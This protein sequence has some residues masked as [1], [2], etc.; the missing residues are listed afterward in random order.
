[1]IDV[2]RLK[3]EIK[4]LSEEVRKHKKI[5]RDP[6]YNVPNKHKEYWEALSGRNKASRRVTKLCT[7]RALLRHRVH[8]SSNTDLTQYGMPKSL[9]LKD[10]WDWVEEEANE[11]QR[12]GE[13]CKTCGH[14]SQ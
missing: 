10:L 11:F 14:I 7:L 2:P 12:Q 5:I 9:E 8:L 3:E 13:V 4:R 1:M 6:A